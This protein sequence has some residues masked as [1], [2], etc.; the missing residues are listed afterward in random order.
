MNEYDKYEKRSLLFPKWKCE[1]CGEILGPFE[2]EVCGPC[3]MKD[4]RFKEELDE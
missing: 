3:R 2:R 1:T 4:P